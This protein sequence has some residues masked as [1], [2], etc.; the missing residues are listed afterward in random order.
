MRNI[1]G[2]QKEATFLFHSGVF[3]TYRIN[4]DFR[5][6]K[7]DVKAKEKIIKT[8]LEYK[9]KNT[10]SVPELGKLLNLSKSAVYRLVNQCYFKTYVICGKMRIDIK[11]FEE[12]YANQFHYIKVDGERPGK[13]YGRT[14]APIT[15]AKVLGLPKTTCYELIERS[16]M[17]CI[18]V[19]GVKR[20]L[21]DSFWSW[22]AK[23]DT[24]KIV[25]SIED[26]EGYVY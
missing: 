7:K 12:W 4:G 11:S 10:M 25:R 22:Y 18:V 17:E 15:V 19:D 2:Q 5:I 14:I 24:Y 3:K 6:K 21:V 16:E 23:Q 1:K 9:D 13:N 20:V 26:V 8:A